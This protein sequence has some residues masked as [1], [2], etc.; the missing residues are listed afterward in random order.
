MRGYRGNHKVTIEH[1]EN[2][3]ITNFGSE[4]GPAGVLH[5]PTDITLRIPDGLKISHF[6]TLCA[7]VILA[8][9]MFVELWTEMLQVRSRFQTVQLNGFIFRMLL[10]FVSTCLWLEIQ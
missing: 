3:V 2:K 9:A 10:L 4:V 6:L 8:A 1:S 7:F 5:L